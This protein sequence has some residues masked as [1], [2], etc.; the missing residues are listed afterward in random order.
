MPHT[1]FPSSS[2][3][4]LE[5]YRTATPP[6]TENAMP[7]CFSAM[8]ITLPPLQL[9]GSDGQEVCDCSDCI[10]TYIKAKPKQ[11]LPPLSKLLKEW[12]ILESAHAATVRSTVIERETN[13]QQTSPQAQTD[14]N[15]MSM[16]EMP[17]NTQ[18]VAPQQPPTTEQVHPQYPDP[19]QTPIFEHWRHTEIPAHPQY[20]CPH[21]T[22]IRQIGMS[23]PPPYYAPHQPPTS[24]QWHQ[25]RQPSE[26]T[27]DFISAARSNPSQSTSSHSRM[28][29]QPPT[30]FHSP[31]PQ[32]QPVVTPS[33][34]DSPHGSVGSNQPNS[35][36]LLPP[37]PK[38]KRRRDQDQVEPMV[39]EDHDDGSSTPVSTGAETEEHVARPPN[40]WILFRRDLNTT[41]KT[42]EWGL[43]ADDVSRRGS[44]L[45]T[46]LPEETKQYYKDLAEKLKRQHQLMYPNYRYRPRRPA[47][48]KESTLAKKKSKARRDEE[49]AGR[50]GMQRVI[51]MR[52]GV[53]PANRT[54]IEGDKVVH[55]N[56]SQK[57]IR[58]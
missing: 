20:P 6:R 10:K 35:A 54:D 44:D 11:S 17:I 21:Q 47:T 38:R 12:S 28:M 51:D 2:P 39:V 7:I 25:T 56:I 18:C 37:N 5:K 58:G 32:G 49:A 16:V 14:N 29:D 36:P 8:R 34:I 43:R 52:M 15:P 55:T 50:R 3:N 48:P 40:A 33:P 13:S 4:T 57:I 46:E 23:A 19:H 22:P 31:F 27:G 26:T 41:L 24:G 1:P 9:P 53:N 30:H 45:W 42:T